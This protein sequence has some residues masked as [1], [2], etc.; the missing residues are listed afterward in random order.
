MFSI[1]IYNHRTF[2][3]V[4]YSIWKTCGGS[5]PQN[6]NPVTRLQSCKLHLAFQ[7]KIHLIRWGRVVL[8][9]EL[10]LYVTYIICASYLLYF[11][12]A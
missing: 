1:Y 5:A 8:L 4:P 12:K 10:Q 2:G 3:T 6:V 11:L 7:K 9:L